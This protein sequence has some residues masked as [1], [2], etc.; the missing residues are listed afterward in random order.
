MTVV[1]KEEPALLVSSITLVPR[2]SR[3][4][5][6]LHQA[7]LLLCWCPAFA[8]VL[9]LLVVVVLTLIIF[10]RDAQHIYNETGPVAD[11][12]PEFVSL[13]NSVDGLSGAYRATAMPGLKPTRS[14]IL[15]R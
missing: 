4:R 14:C 13:P 8:A 12:V 15:V 5:R 6:L 11:R 3:T 7:F 10:R 2:P 1:V 9:L